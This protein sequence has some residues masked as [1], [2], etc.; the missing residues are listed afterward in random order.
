[1]RASLG[2]QLLD[3]LAE[4]ES[5]L[6][7]WSVEGRKRH[8]RAHKRIGQKWRAEAVK[9]VP[10]DEGT[11][12]ARLVANT[13]DA[14]GGD[15]VTE[16]GSNVPHSEFIEFGTQFIA[17]GEVKA[18]FGEPAGFPVV[19]TDQQA[20]TEWPAKTDE[21]IAGSASSREQMPFLRPAF[22]AIRPFILRELDAAYE[23]PTGV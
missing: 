21:A 20:I 18:R 14:G 19:V 1:M 8:R 9:R 17:G 3:D 22:W 12:K 16:V 15:I 7:R 4:F 5:L 2:K 11:L 10:V 13:Y 23:P 6:R